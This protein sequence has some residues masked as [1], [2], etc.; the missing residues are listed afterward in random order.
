MFIFFI[1]SQDELIH[2]GWE[3]VRAS[4]N[5]FKHEYLRSRQAEF[6]Q[7]FFYLQVIRTFITS[8]TS[9]KFGQIGLWSKL[10]LSV[11]KNPNRLIMGKMLTTLSPSFLFESHSFLKVTRTCMECVENISPSHIYHKETKSLLHS[12]WKQTSN[13]KCTTRK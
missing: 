9:S 6:N 10:P 13:K 11:W 12:C 8:R 7:F 1:S 5:T 4:V 3:S 2:V